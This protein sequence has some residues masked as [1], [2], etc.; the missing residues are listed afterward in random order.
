MSTDSPFGLNAI[1]LYDNCSVKKNN[2]KK[3]KN[4]K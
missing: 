4:G 2:K 3:T 1:S